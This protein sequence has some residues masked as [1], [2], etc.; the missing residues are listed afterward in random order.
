MVLEEFK[1]IFKDAALLIDTS[2]E[3]DIIMAFNYG[4]M[5]FLLNRHKLMI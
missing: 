3:R 5:V 1:D 4:L 2:T